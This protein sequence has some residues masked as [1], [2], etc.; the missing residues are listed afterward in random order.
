[1]DAAARRRLGKILSVVIV[2]ASAA[3]S[4]VVYR[5]TTRHP[6]TD[7]AAVRANVIGVAPHVSGPIVELPIV[8]NQ[9]VRTGD[10]LFV[11][12]PRPYQAKLEAARADLALVISTL[13]AQR[14]ALSA[15]EAELVR[16]QADAAYAADYLARVEPLLRRD[17]VTADRVAEA[18]AKERATKADVERA[19]A[20]RERAVKLLAE[21]GELNARKEAAEAAVLSADLDVGYTR[22]VAPFDGWVTNLNISVGQYARQGDPVLA[23]VDGR[24][25]WVVANFRETDLDAIRIGMAADVVLMSYPSRRFAGVVDGIGFAVKD[26]EGGELGGLPHITP[27]LNWVRL[28]RRFPVRVRLTDADPERPFRMGATAVVTIRGGT[29]P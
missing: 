16:S 11:I 3:A 28:A 1:M 7:D 13:E 22:V 2:V 20:E 26:L 15:A 24:A 8:D 12:D 9:P 10:V 19:R 21:V 29:A 25:W 18:R 23:L 14:A 17:F 5:L 6:R 4:L 27:T